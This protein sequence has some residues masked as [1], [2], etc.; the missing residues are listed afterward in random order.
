[1]NLPRLI[2]LAL[3]AAT[4]AGAAEITGTVRSVSG[5]VATVAMNGDVMPPNG[6]RAEFFFTI[7]GSDEAISVA[8]GSVLR[9]DR[10]DL[11]VKIENAT[12]TLESGH[13][14]RFSFSPSATPAAS[15]T[16]S[17]MPEPTSAASPTATSPT[18]TQTPTQP[19]PTP[20]PNEADRQFM[21]AARKFDSHDLI[22]AMAGFTKALE[23]DPTNAK[24]YA[25]RGAIYLRWKQP[26]QALAELNE[27]IRMKPDLAIAH[28]YRGYCYLALGQHKRAIENYDEALRLDPKN[29]SAYNGRG[30]SQNQLG[31][32]KVA[33]ED[34]SQAIAA[35][36]TYVEAYENRAICYK[37][38]GKSQLAKQ[39][40]ATIRE[41]KAAANP[42]AKPAPAPP[43]RKK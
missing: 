17:P 32:T 33:I 2:L 16:P 24:S 35:D 1:M 20:T 37:A 7:P 18:P 29:A 27:A 10:G 25:N 38:M 3:V 36:P 6:A 5:D 21:E 22:G 13:L 14:V 31:R 30:I 28:V 19:A 43:E 42:S 41:L 11:L 40:L 8:S 23:L 39:D 34:F 26:Q 15:P 4:T 12:G 9:I